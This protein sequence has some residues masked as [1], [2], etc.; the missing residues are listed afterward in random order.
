MFSEV[1]KRNMKKTIKIT[2][3]FNYFEINALVSSIV[4]L[5]HW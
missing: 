5:K 1:K 3:L 4:H 2:I